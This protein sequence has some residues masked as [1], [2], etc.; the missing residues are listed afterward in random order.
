M[1][2]AYGERA[3][4]VSKGKIASPKQ[5][6]ESLVSVVPT[7][8]EFE[9]AF[10]NA[11]VSL[12]YLARYYLQ[13]IEPDSSGEEWVPNLSTSAV[14]LEHVLPESLDNWQHIA[15]DIGRAYLRRIGNLALLKMALWSAPACKSASDRVRSSVAVEAST[16]RVRFDN[17]CARVQMIER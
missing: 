10:A 9:N 11:R 6:R 17:M 4:E 8:T 16:V 1:E 2:Q 15:P 3:R 13:A 7:D 12:S 14:N 5:L